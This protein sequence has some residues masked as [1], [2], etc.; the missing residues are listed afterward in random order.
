MVSVASAEQVMTLSDAQLDNVTAAG[1]SVSADLT[2]EALVAGA[3]LIG[4]VG[5]IGS[6]AD[7]IAFI[8]PLSGVPTLHL[9]SSADTRH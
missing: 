4:N 3:F 6:F 9:T 5:D 1:A 2:G 7:V 8:I